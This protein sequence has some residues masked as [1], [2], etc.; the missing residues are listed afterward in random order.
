MPK[1]I[2]VGGKKKKEDMSLLS[3]VCCALHRSRIAVIKDD[4]TCVEM[5]T[6]SFLI[7]RAI[8]IATYLG[9]VLGGREHAV[10]AIYGTS[11]PE[12]LAALLG[13]L[14]V[15]AAYMPV[16]PDTP[17]ATKETLLYRHHVSA[18]LVE[19]TLLEVLVS[20]C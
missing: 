13:V 9:H 18:V 17:A 8:K 10:V 16:G 12:V 5:W 2:I 3:F 11:S 4:L 7:E 20:T 1:T 19:L 14:A 15:P 6:Y